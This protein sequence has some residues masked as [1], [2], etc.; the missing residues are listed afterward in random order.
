MPKDVHPHIIIS[1]QQLFSTHLGKTTTIEHVIEA[2]P[3]Q[4]PPHPILQ[5]EYTVSFKKWQRM[6]LCSPQSMVHTQG[7]WR[8]LHLCGLCPAE[9][10]YKEDIPSNIYIYIHS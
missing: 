3:M 6:A 7:K 4:V 1:H 10:C 9:P 2:T 8:D 5:R